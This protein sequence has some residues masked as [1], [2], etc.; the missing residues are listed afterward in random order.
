MLTEIAEVHNNAYSEHA[1]AMVFW[2][3]IPYS[4]LGG[5]QCFGGTYCIQFQCHEPEDHSISSLM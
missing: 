1:S 5:H 2:I 4:V 3:M